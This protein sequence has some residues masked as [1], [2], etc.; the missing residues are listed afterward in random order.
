MTE[1]EPVFPPDRNP[2][3]DM[4]QGLARLV[5]RDFFS[6]RN[7]Q[8]QQLRADRAGAHPDLLEFERLLQK[9]LKAMGIPMF[10]HECWRSWGRQADLYALGQTKAEPGESAHQYGCAFD[11]V[12]SRHAWALDPKAEWAIIGH[13]GKEV[14]KARG[15]KITWG[16][17]W[18]FY[19]PAHWELTAW[20]EV[21][22]VL[23]DGLFLH[24]AMQQLEKTK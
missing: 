3:A 8:D 19:D 23:D 5:D 24:T 22:R 14:A 6:S 20:R 16:G 2:V 9:R 17:D 4:G 10:S 21:K 7:W 15:L 1:P 18:K 12:H 11:L 13:V